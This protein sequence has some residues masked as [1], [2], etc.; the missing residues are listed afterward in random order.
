MRTLTISTVNYDGTLIGWAA[1]STPSTGVPIS[2]GSSQ[3]TNS[4][5]ALAARNTLTT[6]YTWNITD[7]G[8]I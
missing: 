8:G 4:G 7:G 6:T 1:L 5:A 3:Y 2:F